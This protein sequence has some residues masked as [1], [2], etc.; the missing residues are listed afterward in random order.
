M[1]YISQRYKQVAI[2]PDVFD[3]LTEM[4]DEQQVTT[5]D[6]I[7]LALRSMKREMARRNG[8]AASNP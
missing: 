3:D 2:T 5:S 7:A 8:V 4:R 6:I 1:I